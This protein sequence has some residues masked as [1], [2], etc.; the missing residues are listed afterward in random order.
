MLNPP[1]G[2]RVITRT[3]RLLTPWS[4][5]IEVRETAG[6]AVGRDPDFCTFAERLTESMYVSRRHLFLSIGE[7]QLFVRDLGSHNGT[8]KNGDRITPDVEVPLHA[9]DALT[10]GGQETFFVV[11]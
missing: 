7:G 9:G 4:E 3:F 8:A 2:R 5:I 6:L 1:A 10:L 11:P